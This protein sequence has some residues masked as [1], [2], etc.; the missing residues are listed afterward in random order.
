MPRAGTVVV[1]C[2]GFSVSDCSRDCRGVLDRFASDSATPWDSR[3]SGTQSET[4][5]PRAFLAMHR[6]IGS[7]LRL[8]CLATFDRAPRELRIIEYVFVFFAIYREC[9]F[10]AQAGRT[11]KGQ[12]GGRP[13]TFNCGPAVQT[14]TSAVCAAGRHKAHSLLP[15]TPWRR[16]RS[17]RGGRCG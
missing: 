6:R 10:L 11:L 16:A 9:R 12:F 3:C 8:F 15:R 1:R 17:P 2:D 7:A 13:R 14:F 5:L 4:R